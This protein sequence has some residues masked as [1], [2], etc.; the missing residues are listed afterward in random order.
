MLG[1]KKMQVIRARAVKQTNEES[2]EVNLT[3]TTDPLTPVREFAIDAGSW[4]DSPLQTGEVIL[5]GD[6][7]MIK[8]LLDKEFRSMS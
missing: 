4:S 3:L 1:Y 5:I 8:D 2:G 6:P 7:D